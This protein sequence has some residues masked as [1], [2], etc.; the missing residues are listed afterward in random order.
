MLCDICQKKAATVHLTEI[1]D[2][3][4][5]ELHLCEDCAKE[6]SIKMEQQFSL[7]DLIAGLSDFGKQA[8]DL[9]KVKLVCNSCGMAYD[10]FRKAGR[11]G[12]SDCYISFKK[13]LVSLLK[14]IHGSSQ[15]LG[16]SPSRL[17]GVVKIKSE[18]QEFKSRL[19]YLIETEA[20]EEAAKL[21]DKIKELENK[22]K[23]VR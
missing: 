13:Y 15:H 14:K 2:E 10:N 23:G 21:R 19:Q 7:A 20:F 17:P 8:E 16:K 9:E 6:K 3:V 11:L 18:L 4:M 5:A 22:E 12:C 1:V